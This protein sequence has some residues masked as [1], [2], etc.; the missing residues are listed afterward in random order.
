[1]RYPL[2]GGVHAFF[3]G[4]RRRNPSS[5]TRCEQRTIEA[6]L[7][8][9]KNVTGGS[10]PKLLGSLRLKVRLAAAATAVLVAG[11]LLAPK[12]APTAVPASQERP[13]PLL[14]QEVQRREPVR[15]F[16]PVQEI[17][18]QII[19][20]NVTI[21]PPLHSYPRSMP[22]VAGMTSGSVSSAA[23]TALACGSMY[24]GTSTFPVTSGSS[25]DRPAA[26]GAA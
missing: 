1:M 2:R 17:A 10:A 21:P 26:T 20:H 3:Q 19:A 12:A 22:D 7:E 4:S 14:E 13:V 15:L 23:C 11:A 24:P 18:R 8:P 9:D 5:G 6:M 16:R 25:R